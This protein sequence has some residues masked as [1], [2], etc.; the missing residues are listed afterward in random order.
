MYESNKFANRSFCE[1]KGNLLLLCFGLFFY[2]T[3]FIIAYFAPL[4]FPSLFSENYLK[5][6]LDFFELKQC[7]LI[8]HVQLIAYVSLLIQIIICLVRTLNTQLSTIPNKE[9]WTVK[10]RNLSPQQQIEIET[11]RIMQVEEKLRDNNNKIL[12]HK[13]EE[14]ELSM[15]LSVEQDDNSST[16]SNS[17]LSVENA[18]FVTIYQRDYKQGEEQIRFCNTCR[19]IKPDRSHHCKYCNECYLKLDH[20][21]FWLDKCITYD[22]YK[23]FILTLFYGINFIGFFDFAFLRITYNIAYASGVKNITFISFTALLLVLNALGAVTLCLF[24]YHMALVFYN[25]TSYEY[26]SLMK[27]IE[28]NENFYFDI[29]KNVDRNEKYFKNIS[30]FDVG[31]KKNFYQV[32]GKNPFFWLTPTKVEEEGNNPGLCFEINEK[33]SEEI[34]GSL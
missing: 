24:L 10:G 18:D 27:Q 17:N 16:N 4:Y 29:D 13:G 20:H 26:S 15:D 1:R 8:I 22:N 31:C 14:D 25:Y 23:F 33:F 21:C 5:N 9:P 11:L 30:L 12:V 28:H 34:K 3:F 6:Y 32:F 19:K 7:P 2:G